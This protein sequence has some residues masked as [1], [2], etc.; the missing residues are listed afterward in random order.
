[1]KEKRN[2]PSPSPRR[3]AR[4]LLQAWSLGVK[5]HVQQIRNRMMIRS[6]GRHT[7]LGCETRLFWN[8]IPAKVTDV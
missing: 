6:L 8:K 4:F 3:A 2:V 1:M 7:T 5:W